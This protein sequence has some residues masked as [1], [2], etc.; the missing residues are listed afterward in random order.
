MYNTSTSYRNILPPNPTNCTNHIKDTNYFFKKDNITYDCKPLEKEDCQTTYDD[1]YKKAD[2]YSV[3]ERSSVCDLEWPQFRSVSQE[4]LNF[5]LAYFITAFT[6]SRN[7]ELMLAT[8][9]RPHNSYC[10][11]IDSK[12]DPIFS[13][14]VRQMLH[15]YR[16]RYPGSYAFSSSQSVPVFWTHFSIV[17][18]ELLC[19][20]DLLDNDR[21]WSYAL[22]MAGSELML[23]TNRELVANLSSTN[24]PEIYTESFPIP[25]GNM[26]RIK[27]KYKYKEGAEFDPDHASKIIFFLQ[28]Y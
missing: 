24:E 9:F 8:I 13:R 5:P 28:L 2:P 10:V 18:A 20:R 1:Y 16:A 7:L 3:L 22:D 12:S 11:H 4:E 25:E 14:S 21:P 23:Y 26:H 15:C 27:H 19:L 6:D 17:E